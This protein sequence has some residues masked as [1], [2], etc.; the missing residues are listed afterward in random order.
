[1]VAYSDRVQSAVFWLAGGLTSDGWSALEV[2]VA[3]LR[4]R[5]RARRVVLARPLDRLALGDDVAASLGARPRADPAAGARLAAAL[6]AASAAA[7]AG[8]LALRRARRPAPRAARGRDA[9]RTAS[10]CPASALAGAA[11]AARRRHARAHRPRPD[12]AAG[13][14]ADGRARRAAVPVAAAE[15]GRE[16]RAAAARRATSRVRDRRRRDPRTAPTCTSRAGE[17]VAVVGPN[18]AGKSTLAR[19]VAG[20]QRL[21]GGTVR[22]GGDELAALRGRALARLRAFVP[23]RAARARR[24]DRARGGDDRPL[25]AH[26]PA[27]SARRATTATRSTARWSAPA[28]PRSPTGMLTTLSGGELQ[29]VQIAV[30]LAQEAPVLIA[31]EPTSHLDLGAAAER[32]AAAARARRRRASPSSSSSTTSR[33]PRRSPT[34]SSSMPDGRTVAAGP[35]HAV[36]TPERLREVWRVDAALDVHRRPHRPARPLAGLSGVPDLSFAADSHGECRTRVSSGG[37]S[38]PSRR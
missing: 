33:S 30:A 27:R 31:D 14:P 24:R 23:Q 10:W 15:G 21:A 37:S 25:A 16:R 1:M 8:L 5:V 12:R 2:V 6:L 7:L 9:R 19:A 20:L 29:R 22:W 36:L 13:R 28:S 17:L 18:G 3:V 26:R 38:S 35:P 32:R 11:L 4:R 34:A